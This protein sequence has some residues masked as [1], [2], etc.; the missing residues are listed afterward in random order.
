MTFNPNIPQ[1]NDDLSDSQKDILTNFNKANSSF[2]TNHYAFADLTTNNGKH[3][4]VQTP[5]IVGSAHP[6]TPAAEPAFYGMQD[7]ANVGVIQYSRGPLNAVPSPVTTLQSTAAALTLAPGAKTNVLDFTG[8]TRALCV[9]YAVDT[10]LPTTNNTAAFVT[11]TG[12][13]FQISM[14]VTTSGLKVLSAGNILQI[15]N[16]GFVALNNVYWTMQL[17]RLS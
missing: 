3:N 17:L 10:T 11:W 6:I 2:G 7:S 8:L 14:F 5:L 16:N 12:V 15:G 1:P 9:I 4:N 13:L